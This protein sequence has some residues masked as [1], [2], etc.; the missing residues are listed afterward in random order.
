MADVTC[1]R[2]R[3]IVLDCRR[4]GLPGGCAVGAGRRGRNIGSATPMVHRVEGGVF[5][6]AAWV[7][8]SEYGVCGGEVAVEFHPDKV[9]P[10]LLDWV[11]GFD[12]GRVC[13]V[14][15]DVAVD[16]AVP[17]WS[18]FD[19]AGRSK[20]VLWMEG[21]HVETVRL[22]AADAKSVLRIYDKRRE[23]RTRG[24]GASGAGPLVR[25]ELQQRLSRN[26]LSFADLWRAEWTLPGLVWGMTE[27]MRRLDNGQ[28]CYALSAMFGGLTAARQHWRDRVGQRRESKL[29]GLFEPIDPAPEAVMRDG[30]REALERQ[31]LIGYGRV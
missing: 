30:W 25:V 17:R 22:G 11:H 16:Y 31:G 19:L 18:V 10:G 9:R 4:E 12:P 27:R 24:V 6:G 21:R 8:V 28:K 7:A 15:Y 3:L 2:L 14:R 29:F 20:R 23:E 13:V 26:D 5:E 1:D